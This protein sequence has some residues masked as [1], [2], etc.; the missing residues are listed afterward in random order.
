MD[1]NSKTGILNNGVRYIYNHTEN[2]S[3]VGVLIIVRYGS[4]FDKKSGLAHLLEHILFKGTKKRPLT[5][6]I[7]AELNSIGSEYNAY[8]SRTFTGYHSKSAYI[9]LEQSLDILSDLVANTNFYTK[10]FLAEYEQEKKIVVEE[11]KAIKDNNTKY[12][13]ELLDKNLFKDK[14]SNNSDDDIETIS[15]ITLEDV[16]E[17]YNKYYVGSNIIV[18]INGNLGKHK[19]SIESLLYKYL[20]KVKRGTPNKFI[21]DSDYFNTNPITNNVINMPNAVK[22]VVTLTYRDTGFASRTKYYMLELFRLVFSDLT[23]GRL[24]Q[25]IREK[26]GLVYSIKSVHYSYDHLGYLCIRTNTDVNNIDKLT[27][28]LQRQIELVKNS[29]LT[30]SE[31]EIAKK[32]YTG[33]LLMDLEDSMTLS[34]YN[35]YELFYHGDDYMSYSNIVELINDIK[36]EEI[37]KFIS[38]LL[39]S[40]GILTI[41]KP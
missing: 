15:S 1:S 9:H 7:M 33:K 39:S 31:F 20:G 4:G 6:D 37:N 25:E 3:S 32:N 28:E 19:G 34:E 11:L 41:I 38:R 8:T 17:T 10:T 30:V 18:S 5:K 21:F 14:L 12:V 27:A 23:S 35:A 40:E 26:R 36:L 13:L 22:A 2:S 16:I 29:G 24:F